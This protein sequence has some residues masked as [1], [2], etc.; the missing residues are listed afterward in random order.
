MFRSAG[1]VTYVSAG[2]PAPDDESFSLRSLIV[3]AC[4]CSCCCRVVLVIAIVIVLVRLPTHNR[5]FVSLQPNGCA[6]NQFVIYEVRRRYLPNHSRCGWLVRRKADRPR[7]GEQA[8]L[9]VCVEQVHVSWLGAS[10]GE[11][12]ENLCGKL[13]ESVSEVLPLSTNTQHYV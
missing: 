13:R 8:H 9:S 7:R 10:L 11:T 3:E 6:T 12:Y 2:R 5:R 4:S 1:E